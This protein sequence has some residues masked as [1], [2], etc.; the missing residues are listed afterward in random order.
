MKKRFALSAVSRSDV[1]TQA[2]TLAQTRA[3]LPPLQKQLAQARNQLMIYLGRFPNQ[4]KAE[5][6]ELA[7]LHLPEELPLSLPSKLVEQRPDV[8]ASEAQLHEASANIGVAIANQLPQFSITSTLGST[9][10]AFDALFSPGTAVWSIA[11]SITQTIFDAGA[12]EHRKRSAVAAYDQAAAQYRGTVL[13]AF[14]DVANALC[15]LQFDAD[16]LKAQATAEKIAF[17]SLDLAQRQYRLG[18][19]DHLTLLNAQQTYQQALINLVQARANR[20]ADTVALYQALGGGWWN[21]SDVLAPPRSSA[22][23]IFQ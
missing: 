18:A 12:T 9:S 10:T 16:A 19:I 3:T 2:S 8:R 4:D 11:G 17:D 6:F 1:L 14:Q 23:E 15:A 13:S 5:S 21:R 22:I 7:S 20:Y